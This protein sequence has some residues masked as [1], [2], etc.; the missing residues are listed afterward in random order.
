MGR[1]KH[2]IPFEGQTLVERA[3][4]VAHTEVE[5]ICLVGAGEIPAS[6]RDLERIDDLPGVR[7]PLAGMIAAMER[8]P[9]TAWLF[10]ACDLPWVHRE[11]LR[12]L[13]GQRHI[14]AP[15][16]IPV[17]WHRDKN[18]GG[19]APTHPRLAS[20]PLLAVYEP[21]ALPLLRCAAASGSGPS[22]LRSATGVRTPELP[23]ELLR[24]WRDA[25]HPQDLCP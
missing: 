12:W 20:E 25:D 16:I 19:D 9:D 5:R 23:G 22:T 7:G 3:V 21:A 15:A 10:M 13:L 24:A 8:W 18:P 4:A 14:M 6:L 2:L 17:A 1:P 11:A